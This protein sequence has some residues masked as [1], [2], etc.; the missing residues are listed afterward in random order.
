MF[1]TETYYK[2]LETHLQVSS[3]SF[4]NT[5]SGSY[6]TSQKCII[7]FPSIVVY[8]LHRD[9]KKHL[10]THKV[11]IQCCIYIPSNPNKS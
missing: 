7:I 10:Q 5:I 1:I 4:V 3:D 11:H 6:L 2:P 9:I 8:L